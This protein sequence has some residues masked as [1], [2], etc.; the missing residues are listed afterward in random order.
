MAELLTRSRATMSVS[1]TPSDSEPARMPLELVE[2]FEG[3]FSDLVDTTNMDNASIW[4]RHPGLW[5]APRSHGQ[6]KRSTLQEA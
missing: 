1:A 3:L 2:A 6:A 5:M 4:N